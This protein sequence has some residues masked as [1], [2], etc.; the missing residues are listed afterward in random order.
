[1]GI[2][3]KMKIIGICLIGLT[4][5]AGSASAQLL[6]DINCNGYPWEVQDA[7][8]MARLMIEHCDLYA[9]PCWENSDFDQDGQAPTVGDMIYFFYFNNLPNYPRN[10]L[11]DT[12]EVESAVA[13][14]GESVALG[15]WISTVDTIMGLQFL[16]DTDT[17]Y[18]QFD[19][20]TE[21]VVSP[22]L[23]SNCNGEIYCVTQI[24]INNPTVLNPGNYHIC[25]LFFT[26][27]PDITQP[28]TTPLIF[29]SNPP[30]A[31][32]S[33]LAN[34]DFF[35]PVM[36]DAEIEILPLSDIEPPGETIPTDFSITAYPN[37]F[38]D[39]LNISVIS[40][41]ATQIAIYDIMGRPIKT[42]AVNAG[43]NLINWNATDNSGHFLS[44]GIYFIGEK[45]NRSF[46][47][48][49]YLK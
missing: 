2:V 1:M 6:G 25:D 23:Y 13:H 19:S 9:P 34:P 48:V 18:I 11:S 43:P 29:S 15:V 5:I 20:L 24:Q 44:A 17:D 16:L 46:R 32:F 14:P 33:G 10:P 49:L 4:V 35:L 39:A 37:P 41:G 21:R 36:V 22:L 27:D 42:F 3:M 45:Q 26:I 40:D 8:L 47:K 30:L 12:L 28:V 31:L 7:V 38:N